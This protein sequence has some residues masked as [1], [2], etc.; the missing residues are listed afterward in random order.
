M[1][2]SSVLVGVLLAC[3][4]PAATVKAPAP[5][6]PASVATVHGDAC[7]KDIPDCEA[8]CAMREANRTQH[9]EWFDRR[10]AAVVLGKNPDKAVGYTPPTIDGT[11]PPP[12]SK[13][14]PA[15]TSADCDPPF[16]YST[17]GVKMWKLDCV[18]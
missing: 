5:S 8:A 3:E 16:S 11:S 14:A 4:P 2:R 1:K 15:T 17:D 18:E 6:A 7:M 10:C 12:P 9:L 13:H